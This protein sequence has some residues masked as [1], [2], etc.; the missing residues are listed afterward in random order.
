M[1]QADSSWFFTYRTESCLSTMILLADI[2]KTQALMDEL[3]LQ[4]DFDLGRAA[5]DSSWIKLLPEKAVMVLA[6]DSSGGVFLAY[7][8]G[9][10]ER[11]PILHV[12]SEGQ[13]GCIAA[14]LTEL[15]A[16][17]LALPYWR[18]LLK[19][20]DSGKLQEMRRTARFS[21]QDYLEEYAEFPAAKKRILDTLA[22]PVI[23]D[24]V[25]LLHDCVHATDCSV[26]AQDGWRYESLF[27]HF[28]SSDNPGWT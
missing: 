21:E 7:G 22:V 8:D 20:S 6:G 4:F 15:I 17:M 12:T 10:I 27:N 14:N 25:K 5:R 1:K 13:A 11:C 18:D 24:P 3:A 28:K 23:A 19:F 26:V 16:M 9:E 2:Q